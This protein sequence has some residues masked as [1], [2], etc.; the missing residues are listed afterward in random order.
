LLAVI[1][2][3][4]YRMNYKLDQLYFLSDSELDEMLKH[5]PK[6]LYN[7]FSGDYQIIPHQRIDDPIVKEKRYR[8]ED[9]ITTL[10]FCPDVTI[11]DVIYMIEQR[12]LELEQQPETP[13]VE[14]K[15]SE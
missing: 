9:I 11:P 6:I 8:M 15:E 13:T 14:I 2:G 12:Q 4:N 3:G 1:Q 10:T 5:Q 7:P